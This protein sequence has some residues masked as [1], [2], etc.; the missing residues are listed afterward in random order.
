MGGGL[1]ADSVRLPAFHFTL[2]PKRWQPPRESPPINP[3]DV[4]WP[5][6]RKPG[7]QMRSAS[8]PLSRVVEMK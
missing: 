8:A 2:C 3:F 7:V 4:L 6:S 1:R 5:W